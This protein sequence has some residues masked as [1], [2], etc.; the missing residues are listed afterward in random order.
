[1]LDQRSQR[2]DVSLELS[3]WKKEI[4]QKK[5]A[6]YQVTSTIAVEILMMYIFYPISIEFL[7]WTA[8]KLLRFQTWIREA[9]KLYDLEETLHLLSQP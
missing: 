6:H 5:A 8:L 7:E 2:A 9:M 1:M 4:L 3:S